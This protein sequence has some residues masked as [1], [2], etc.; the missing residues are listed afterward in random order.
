M[1]R[2]VVLVDTN[3]LLR[4]VQ[5]HDPAYPLVSEA[6]DRLFR[7]GAVLYYTSQNL[8]EFWNTLT[9]VLIDLTRPL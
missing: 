3:V 1:A 4:W 8:G 9:R 6:I 7:S 5:R 2:D